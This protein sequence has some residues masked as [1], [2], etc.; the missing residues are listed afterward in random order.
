MLFVR[1]AMCTGHTHNMT[2]KVLRGVRAGQGERFRQVSKSR[3]MAGVPV[4]GPPSAR[5]PSKRDGRDKNGIDSR[6]CCTGLTSQLLNPTLPGKVNS[7]PH[8]LLSTMSQ[9]PAHTRLTSISHL[10][11]E[12]QKDEQEVVAVAPSQQLLHRAV[13]LLGGTSRRQC[14]PNPPQ[15]LL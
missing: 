11:D 3:P 5:H 4:V 8:T 6:S 12:H 15:Q 1:V 7:A 2:R 14:L 13:Q 10:V 9:G